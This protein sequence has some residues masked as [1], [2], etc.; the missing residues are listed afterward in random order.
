MVSSGAGALPRSRVEF[1]YIPRQGFPWEDETSP[2]AGRS[3]L[4]FINNGRPEVTPS[5][6]DE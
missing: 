2:L 1:K 4:Q 3:N 6:Q 5:F